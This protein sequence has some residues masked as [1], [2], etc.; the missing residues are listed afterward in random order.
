MEMIREATI[1]PVFITSNGMASR[2]PKALLVTDLWATG[3]VLVCFFLWLT[4]LIQEK[5]ISS[6]RVKTGYIFFLMSRFEHQPV[7]EVT[8]K[9]TTAHI[10]ERIISEAKVSLMIKKIHSIDDK[11]A[12]M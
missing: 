6:L 3:K 12:G 8:G 4:L 2:L 7:K 10:A 9:S 5:S 11:L 1:L